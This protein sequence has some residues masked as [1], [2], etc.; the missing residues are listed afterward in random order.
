MKKP[1][2]PAIGPLLASE[3]GALTFSPPILSRFPR[4][5][6]SLKR[7]STTIS[8]FLCIPLSRTSY[9]SST[10]V[11]PNFLPIFEVFWSAFW[12]FLRDKGLDVPIITLLLDFFSVKEVVEGFLYISK[13]CSA[14]LIISHLSSSCK[15]WKERYFFIGGRN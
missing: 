4:W 7:P 12:S 14:S 15:N 11:H 8:V 6:A 1:P 10:F 5:S 13:R 9:S 3:S 2:L